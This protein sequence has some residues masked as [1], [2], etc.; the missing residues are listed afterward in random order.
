MN[1]LF[2]GLYSL[3]VVFRLWYFWSR[4]WHAPLR[5]G[6][7]Y[8]L[9]VEVPEGWHTTQPGITWW[10]RYRASIIVPHALEAVAFLAIAIWG[11]WSQLP[12]LSLVAPV[13]VAYYTGVI[14]WWRRASGA[15]RQKPGRVA[16]DLT[17]RRVRDSFSWPLET[18]LLLLVAGSWVA[19]AGWGDGHTWKMPVTFTYTVA[20][21]TV[22]KAVVVRQ[23]W[24]L[25]AERTEDYQR[26]QNLRRKQAGAVLDGM[27]VMLVAGLA[28]YA[29]VHS[30]GGIVPVVPVRWA[31]ILAS[32][33]VWI[34]MMAT[35]ARG[36]RAV[37][38]ALAELPPVAMAIDWRKGWWSFGAFMAGLT[39]LL[40]WPW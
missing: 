2:L 37:D 12:L 20:G 33:V 29:A 3:T 21:L 32:V 36:E 19:L 8:F 23:G 16:V 34:W 24:A 31:A 26:F 10:R 39:V 1:W 25:P 30:L 15:D 18:L 38:R 5:N 9:D 17:A 6:E 22:L 4:G 7:R 13:F 11:R 35:F 40:I 27:R 14:I 28:G